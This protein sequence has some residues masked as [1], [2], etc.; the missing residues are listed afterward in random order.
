MKAF[1]PAVGLS[2]SLSVH[3][4]GCVSFAR[5]TLWPR[6]GPAVNFETAA[7]QSCL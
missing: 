6:D 2:V 5:L 7:T 1:G 3:V 4:L